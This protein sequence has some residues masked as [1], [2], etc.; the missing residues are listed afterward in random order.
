MLH[1]HNVEIVDDD[2]AGEKHNG[3][4][5]FPESDRYAMG[6]EGFPS[7]T[8]SCQEVGSD[9]GDYAGE[10]GPFHTQA[11]GDQQVRSAQTNY[12]FQ[13]EVDGQ[14]AKRVNSLNVAPP[15][16]EWNVESHS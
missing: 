15:H 4:H 8:R 16:S 7:R 9:D 1:Q 11:E 12:A 10:H 14:R 6:S 13:Y 5:P 3:L 2:L